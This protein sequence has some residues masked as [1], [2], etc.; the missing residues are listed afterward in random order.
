M[1]IFML[2]KDP[3]EAARY[4]YNKH[5]VKMILECAQLLS[6]AHRVL[7][8][9]K[10]IT[11]SKTGRKQTVYKLDI[12]DEREEKLYKANHVNHPSAI[13]TRQCSANYGYVYALYLALIQEY[14]NR[15]PNM[16]KGKEIVDKPQHKSA[17]LKIILA[18]L[19]NNIKRSAHIK[20]PDRS[21][22]AMPDQYKDDC[23]IQAYRNY[24]LGEKDL[25]EYFIKRYEHN[26]GKV[27]E[28]KIYIEQPPFVKEHLELSLRT[29]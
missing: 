28:N 27:I 1:N 13:W 18:G 14:K 17:E 21:L 20:W 5:V 2:S 9:K 22:Q 11:E 16:K 26:L 29:A 7:D 6:T 24:Y 12:F 10:M 4:H 8:G 25:E 15:Y 19:P 23:A 3:K